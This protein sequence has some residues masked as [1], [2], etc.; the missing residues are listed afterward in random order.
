MNQ[1]ETIDDHNFFLI[2]SIKRYHLNAKLYSQIHILMTEI[3]KLS[4][5]MKRFDI[6]IQILVQQII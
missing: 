3:M 6:H 4:L 5:I 2:L 1:T